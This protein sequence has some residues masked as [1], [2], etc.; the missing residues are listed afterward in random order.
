MTR[1]TFLSDFL[2]KTHTA[3]RFLAPVSDICSS[4]SFLIQLRDNQTGIIPMNNPY[5]GGIYKI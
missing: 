2:L 3:V 5:K 1:S 4:I